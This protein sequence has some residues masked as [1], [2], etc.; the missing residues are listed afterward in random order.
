MVCVIA[1]IIRGSVAPG[2]N[3]LGPK[4]GPPAILKR[5]STSD[6]N[7]DNDDRRLIGELA[8]L[9]ASP[10]C[11]CLRA[12]D[13]VPPALGL[14]IEL[15][16]LIDGVCGRFLYADAGMVGGP[17][18]PIGTGGRLLAAAAITSLWSGGRGGGV[19]VRDRMLPELPGRLGTRPAS[20]ECLLLGEGGGDS[21][22][23]T[24]A[25]AMFPA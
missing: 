4:D 13:V 19:P 3:A 12:R 9:L 8:P 20:L 14:T 23:S 5:W 16:V 11:E 24:P 18:A 25:V 17:I 7:D 15:P 2:G 1:C 6:V 21:A 10:R 22:F